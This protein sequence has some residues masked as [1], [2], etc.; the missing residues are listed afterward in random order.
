M[1][2]EPRT[3]TLEEAQHRNHCACFV[4]STDVDDRFPVLNNPCRLVQVHNHSM[5]TATSSPE[6]M[7]LAQITTTQITAMAD[8]KQA[9][10]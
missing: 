10:L 4:P 1:T 9:M 8:L 6:S 7:S 3:M 5:A 2:F